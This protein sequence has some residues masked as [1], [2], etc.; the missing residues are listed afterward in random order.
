MALATG[1]ARAAAVTE[2]DNEGAASLAPPAVALSEE[3]LKALEAELVPADKLIAPLD[4]YRALSAIIGKPVK[5]LVLSGLDP[6]KCSVTVERRAPAVYRGLRVKCGILRAYS[7]AW[8][9]DL[10]KLIERLE[11]EQGGEEYVFIV[12]HAGKPL[13]SDVVGI[14][15]PPKLDAET[16]I[17]PPG[18]AVAD[19][20]SPDELDKEAIRETKQTRVLEARKRRLQAQ[21][22]V[23]EELPPDPNAEPLQPEP[24]PAFQGP[25]EELLTRA[26]VD[27]LWKER[28]EKADLKR[29]IEENRRAM[30]ALR[31]EIS[32]T[33]QGGGQEALVQAIQ[34]STASMMESLKMTITNVAEQLKATQAAGQDQFK[35]MVEMIKLASDNQQKLAQAQIDARSKE[36]DLLVKLAESKQDMAMMSSERQMALIK[37]GMSFAR[38]LQ[39]PPA[40]DEELGWANKA[41]SKLVDLIT[42]KLVAGGSNALAGALPGP[43]AAAAAPGLTEEQIETAA[44]RIARR[45]AEKIRGKA[46]AGA[47]P[48]EAPAPA[49]KPGP[50]TSKDDISFFVRAAWGQMSK[51]LDT[52]PAQSTFT[53]MVA[54]GPPSFLAGI[55]K[56]EKVQEIIGLVAPYVEADQ[57]GAAAG[58]MLSPE[59]QQWMLNQIVALK[60]IYARRLALQRAGPK[61]ASAPPAAGKPRAQKPKPPAAPAAAPAPAPAPAAP[62]AP[63]PTE[64]GPLGS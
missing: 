31:T 26:Q 4:D 56:A 11:E 34:Q 17:L 53:K 50:A 47:A 8:P 58:K 12:K 43:E 39:A 64:G 7:C 51:E 38:D 44:Q 3:D 22:E 63:A 21:R 23:Q 35:N 32:N 37:E 29:Q 40:A 42:G 49:A 30:D 15:A 24:E 13:W 62:Q 16:S 19:E 41:G 2:N 10:A 57:I 55:G 5:W 61:P 28:E 45:V 27:A 52:L 33:K 48:A 36:T 1:Q 9:F 59:A 18:K 20:G 25:Q 6:Y 54:E 14:D 60:A 46:A